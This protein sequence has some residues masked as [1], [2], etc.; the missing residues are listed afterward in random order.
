MSVPDPNFDPSTRSVPLARLSSFR[1]LPFRIEP[2]AA[3]LA[4]LKQEFDLLDLRKLRFE[5]TLLPEGQTD[6]RLEATLGATAVQP[7]SVT[8]APVTTRIDTPVRRRYLADYAP[9]ADSEA[10][11]PEDD[12]AEPM[13]NVVDLWDVLR[14]ELALALPDFPRAEG[15]ELEQTVFAAPGVTPMADD[16]VKPFA[17]LA[18]LKKKLES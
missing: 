2:T 6:W 1:P 5:G 10:E 11:M 18:E 8:L 14:E 4:A 7:C 12:S 9:P 15:V 3:E 13:P 16:E 17:G